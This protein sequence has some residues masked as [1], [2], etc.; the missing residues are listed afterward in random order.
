MAPTSITRLLPGDSATHPPSRPIKSPQSDGETQQLKVRKDRPRL[1]QRATTT[2]TTP[3]PSSPANKRK[4]S[5]DDLPRS[6]KKGRKEVQKSGNT[7]GRAPQGQQSTA[8]HLPNTPQKSIRRGRN[9][10][11]EVENA[12]LLQGLIGRGGSTSKRHKLGEFVF[13]PGPRGP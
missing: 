11:N 5:G 13:A 4:R 6:I 9:G 8:K 10:K 1:S 2:T 3:T 12:A 7:Q